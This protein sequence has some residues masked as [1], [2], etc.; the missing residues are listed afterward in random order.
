VSVHIKLSK[1]TSV[2]RQRHGEDFDPATQPLDTNL[3]MRLGG[4]KQHGRYWM[5]DSTVDF[6][7]VLNLAEIQARSTS[8]SLPI[9][10]R[11]QSSQEQMAEL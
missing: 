3:L 9:R 4:G 1:Y 6:A 8:S 11:Q 7:S 2:A 10:S 5:E